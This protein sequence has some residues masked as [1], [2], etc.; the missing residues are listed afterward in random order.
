MSSRYELRGVS[1]DKED[2]HRAI[3]S[4]DKGL[5]PNAFCK[6][7][8]DIAAG[9][10]AYCNVIHTD[11]AGSKTALAYVYWKETGD[12]SVWRGIAQDAIVM[13]TDDLACAGVSDGILISS[14]I[15]RNKALIPGEVIS[16]LVEG[17]QDFADRM[18]EL[19]IRVVLGGGETADVG[20]IVRTIDVGITAF[21]RLE[22]SRIIEVKIEPGD[23]IVGL[24]S[25]GQSTY[26][27]VY[28][29]GMGCNGLTSAR[30]DLLNATYRDQYPESFDPDTK[31]SLVYSGSKR[32]SDE[33]EHGLD[34]GRLLLSP[35]RTYLP[36]IR[37]LLGELGPRVHALIHCTGG[38][39]T[40]VMRFARDLHIIK[41]NLFEPPLIFKLI[42]EE[43]KMQP[44]EMY[45]VFNMGHRL[46]VYLPADAAETALQVAA[47][48]GVE[49][50][51][52][53]R[54]EPASAGKVSIR[55]PQGTFEYP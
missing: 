34:I 23:V 53:G 38:G 24:A 37:R 20:D 9:D 1:A 32:L 55:V 48:F 11:T 13:N 42:Q 39:Q 29:S 52:I 4:L 50:R 10:D 18:N 26:E 3:A 28:N 36:V 54:C 17:T 19:G 16:T 49:S 21:A 12:L 25:F 45:H 47:A 8:P 35:T 27:S 6:I 51:V 46:E 43:S 14:N 44:R 2:V 7:I 30:H 41:D 15:A 22:R 33:G 31:M 5:F 40:K